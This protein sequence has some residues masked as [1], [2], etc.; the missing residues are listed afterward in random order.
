MVPEEPSPESDVPMAEAPPVEPY[1][2]LA[3]LA[4]PLI[5]AWEDR[6]RRER[7]FF[8]ATAHGVARGAPYLERFR[9]ILVEEGVP[10]SLALL[11]VIES[12]FRVRARGPVG[13]VGLWQFQAPTARRFG[14]VVNR[15]RDDRLN[16]E[17]AARAAA[18]YLAF[19][20]D[21]YDDWPLALAAYNCG[22]GRVDRALRRRPG[23]TFWD[24]AE[25]RGLPR[26]SRAY[27]PRFLA[28]V[29]VVE[30]AKNCDRPD[31]Q[32]V[33]ARQGVRT[34]SGRALSPTAQRSRAWPANSDIT[35]DR[36]EAKRGRAGS[37]SKAK[38]SSSRPSPKR[39]VSSSEPPT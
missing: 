27:V 35:K 11:P 26:I 13:S 22:E 36:S 25:H 20:Y 33:M 7:K 32:A 29:R 3:C 2:E 37:S 1:S 31:G 9:E 18:R 39:Q 24:L 12:G 4:H 17:L 5:D 34:S 23:A 6:L 21:R 30:D 38:R 16:P 28:V 15:H 19:L 8:L 10:P 14:L